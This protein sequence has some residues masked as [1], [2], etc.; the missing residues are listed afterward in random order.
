VPTPTELQ[1]LNDHLY[2]SREFFPVDDCRNGLVLSPRNNMRSALKFVCVLLLPVFLAGNAIAAQRPNILFLFSDDQRFDTIHALG[3]E[4]IRTP[5]LDR[6]AQSGTAFTRAY[7][8]GGNSGAVCMPSRA[9]LMSGRSLFRI[10]NHL[11]G[12]TT[13]PEK[14]SRAGYLTFMTG[15]W[16][17]GAESVHRAFLSGN[18]IFLGGMGSPYK[19]PLQDIDPDHEFANKRV[20]GEHSVKLF[21]DAAIQF[22]KQEKNGRPFLCYAAFNCPHD[23]RMAPQSYHDYYNAHKP[24][25]PKNYLPVHPFNNSEMTIR[26]EQLAPW[27][28]TTEVV[29]QHL[30]DYYAYIHFMD[31]QIGRI[32]D[33]LKATGQFENTIIVFSSDNG[34]AIGSHGLFG[35]QNLYDHATH[36]PLI[37][38]G[39]GIPAGQQRDAFCYLFDIF[40]T[41]AELVGGVAAPDGNEGKSLAP[42]I[43]GKTATHRDSIFT[44]Y[45]H[46]HR[47]VRDDRWKLI[48]YTQINKTQLF[49]LQADPAEMNDLAADPS[50]AGEVARLTGLLKDWQQKC[51]DEQPLT[52]AKPV[53]LEFDF[54]KIKISKRPTSGVE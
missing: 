13:W 1:A 16:H 2:V 12:Q 6:L 14:F 41:L 42:V 27:P 15:K 5:N 8:M 39:P 34:L 11:K 36:M 4:H 50:R 45:R 54:R 29:R 26:D 24:P 43:T 23:P 19:L 21:A 47:A 7:I 18:A 51:G 46:I 33:T 3:N 30:A 52:T 49:D 9:M 38:T 32:L 28:R 48:A 44:A 22:L 53:P 37:F 25:L 31:D 10:N 40:P 20:S 17:N 35:K